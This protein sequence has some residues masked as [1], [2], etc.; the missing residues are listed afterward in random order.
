MSTHVANPENAPHTKARAMPVST[1]KRAAA[2]SKVQQARDKFNTGTEYK[3]DDNVLLTLQPTAK[4]PVSLVHAPGITSPLTPEAI[5][6]LT[7]PDKAAQGDHINYLKEAAIVAD[8]DAKLIVS[9]PSEMRRGRFR[10]V[11]FK[12]LGEW[13][14]S[15]HYRKL[16]E[17]RLRGHAILE[18]VRRQ[19]REQDAQLREFK[20]EDEDGVSETPYQ[21][22]HPGIRL[23]PR[24]AARF[25]EVDG[26]IINRLREAIGDQA[27]IFAQDSDQTAVSADAWSSGRDIEFTPLMAGPYNKQL[28]FAD[29]LTMHALAHEAANHNPIAKRIAQVIPQF[30][31]GKS[32][33]ATVMKAALPT[34]KKVK[35]GNKV[36]DQVVDYK[37]ESQAILDEHWH[38]NRMLIRSKSILRDLVVFGEQFIRYFNAP[39]GLKIRQLDPSTVW[40]IVTD[41]DDLETVFWLHQQYP[42]R[43]LWMTDVGVP[44]IKYIIRQVPGPLFYHMKI[45]ASAGEVRGRSELFAILGWLK[46]LKEFSSDRVV[47]NKVA[48]LFCLDISVEGGPQDV[49]N[50]RAQFVTPPTP[51]SFFIHNKAAEIQGIRAEIGAG[52]VTSDW[53]MLL[54]VI[55]AG[56][57]ISKEYLGI[58][59]G[60][61]K[62][63]ALVGT[64]PDIKTFETYQEIM[65]DFYQQDAQRVF[66][67]SKEMGRLP[68]GLDVQVEMTYPAIAEENR[69]EKLKDIAFEESMSHMSHR[70]A[71]SM[72]TKE[73]GITEYDYDDEQRQ[74]AEE[75]AQ[76]QL[77]INQA[78][79]QLVKG[80]DSS[81]TAQ[82]GSAAGAQGG[83]GGQ[84]ATS[85]GMGKTAKAPTST[86]TGES[87]K[88]WQGRD[89]REVREAILHETHRLRVSRKGLRESQEMGVKG[90]KWGEQHPSSIG[91]RFSRHDVGNFDWKARHLGTNADEEPTAEDIEKLVTDNTVLT[92]TKQQLD[93]FLQSARYAYQQ[94]H[95]QKEASNLSVGRKRQLQPNR[96]QLS[97]FT[98]KR[99]RDQKS[100]DRND[101]VTRGRR[102]VHG[103]YNEAKSRRRFPRLK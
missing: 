1:P 64:E 69:S 86:P 6:G 2:V 15:K 22:T 29:Y 35:Q 67:R 20:Q 21:D 37:R 53:E 4:F 54:T 77:M 70:R 94:T 39:W 96:Q 56:A 55:S 103:K 87:K 31:L 100:M 60:G 43:F 62:A 40:E 30:V 102:A 101:I 75:D 58:S 27:D 57:G 90:M 10:E 52:D 8:I 33:K 12:S 81:K 71:A 19:E 85:G 84:G 61:S 48:N 5:L 9:E 3:Q 65:E 42:T 83:Q 32:V 24:I 7:E 79:G 16:R 28:Y 76:K 89:P 11:H 14:N 97:Q 98:P 18:A 47:R 51:G 26:P 68:K 45:N 91:K 13:M 41:V 50:V 82:G 72:A 73:L 46:R 80:A 36:V 25:R 88:G 74:I 93:G 99:V 59:S 44:T 34:G 49:E 23:D 92:P 95:K 66:D 17:S 63:G 38:K 78:Y